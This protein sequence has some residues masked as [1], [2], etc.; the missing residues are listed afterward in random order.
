MSTHTPGPEPI[1][2][3]IRDL[4]SENKR[5]RAALRAVQARIDGEW[6]HPALVALGPLSTDTDLD[7]RY[8]IQSA[9]AACGVEG[10]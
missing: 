9:L 8:I 3:M 2:F 7:V 10:S 5:L 4:R 6:D 1:L